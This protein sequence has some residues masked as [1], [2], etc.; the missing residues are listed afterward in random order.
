MLRDQRKLGRKEEGKLAKTREHITGSREIWPNFG[1]SYFHRSNEGKNG[2]SMTEHSVWPIL[3]RTEDIDQSSENKLRR[4]EELRITLQQ[5]KAQRLHL[6]HQ[7]VEEVRGKREQIQQKKMAHL[8]MVKERIQKAEK[9]RQ[10]SLEEIV[11]RAQ[12]DEMKVI[13]EGG[14]VEII[15]GER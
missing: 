11:Q 3:R 1:Q 2:R 7:R 5:E 8:E 14:K 10:K 12:E 4:A 15:T 9:N 13:G 6:L